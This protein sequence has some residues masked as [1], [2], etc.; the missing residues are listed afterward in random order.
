MAIAPRCATNGTGTS[1]TIS[2]A[3]TGWTNSGAG[4]SG[5]APAIGDIVFFV[6]GDN[7]ASSTLSQ[8]GGTGTWT[9]H[10]SDNNGGSAAMTS[11]V[12]WRVFD[13]TE[14][15]PTFTI[16]SASKTNWVI[17]ALAPDTSDTISI[18]VWSTVK[19]DTTA[20]TTHTPNAATAA[21]SGECSLVMGTCAA[22]SNGTTAFTFA[23]PTGWTIPSAGSVTNAGASN[24]K[25]HGTVVCYEENVGAGSVAPGAVTM[26]QS[27]TG[28]TTANLYQVLVLETAPPAVIPNV[29]MAPM[30]GV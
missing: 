22:S 12:A 7:V 11:G 23:A 15:A 16:T 4:P 5:T 27:G 6:V 3:L 25:G 8:S 28:T 29:I 19:L 21:G 10:S 2:P 30:T 20:A 9:I 18:D 24:S 14:T 13:G 17:I 26:D 1:A